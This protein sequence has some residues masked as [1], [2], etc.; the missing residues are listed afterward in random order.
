MAAGVTGKSQIDQAT[1]KYLAESRFT[2]QERP[3]VIAASV[4]TEN[5]P[6]NS[7]PA[8]NIPKYGTVTTFALTEGIDMAQAQ[9]ITDTLM[10][11]TPTEYGAQVILTDLMLMTVKD[12]FFR[13]AGRILGDSFDRQREET[14]ADD[15]DNFSS[16]AGGAGNALT[17][18][19][20]MAYH[21]RIK[22]NAVA[23]GTAARGGEPGPDPITGIVTP[24]ISHDL[25][26]TMVGGLG[27]A[28]ATQIVP[29]LDRASQGE[30]YDVGGVTIKTT[31]NLNKDTSDD[32]KCG[33]FSRESTIL[34]NLGG[35]PDMEKDRNPSLRAWELNFVGRWARGEYFDGW[36]V[37]PTHDSALPTS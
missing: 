27:A 19:A 7:G 29:A 15:F 10:T 26:R 1:G 11:L 14:L 5:L 20:V 30:Q 16:T 9:Q 32:V 4:R 35:G 33:F 34:V 36:G 8:V 3:G 2:L 23:D 18:G 6:K 21:A 24:A 37:E 25:K 28:A 17:V 13:V 31:V 12:E 22:G